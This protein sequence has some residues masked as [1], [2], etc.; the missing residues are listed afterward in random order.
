MGLWSSFS[1]SFINNG[2][3]DLDNGLWNHSL[4][5]PMNYEVNV[6]CWIISKQN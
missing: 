4:K 2:N 3:K 1:S 5:H 6:G